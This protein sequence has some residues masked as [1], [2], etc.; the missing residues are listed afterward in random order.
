MNP[1]RLAWLLVLAGCGS[2]KTSMPDDD[3]ERHLLESLLAGRDVLV[4]AMRQQQLLQDSILEQCHLDLVDQ[5]GKVGSRK[6]QIL[7]E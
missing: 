7:L 3:A 5:E 4:D 1:T 2:S 6:T